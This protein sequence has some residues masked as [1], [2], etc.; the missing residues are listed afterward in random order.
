VRTFHTFQYEPHSHAFR[1]GGR[2]RLEIL[3]A[4]RLT[5]RQFFKAEAFREI[6]VID[7]VSVEFLFQGG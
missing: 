5:S 3:F 1:E 4:S 6:M 7:S 2:G